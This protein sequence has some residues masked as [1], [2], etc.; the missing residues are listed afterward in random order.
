MN[1]GRII[2]TYLGVTFGETCSTEEI[3]GIFCI[4]GRLIN[5]LL[6]IVGA[7]SLVMFVVGGLQYMISGGDEKAL[8]TAKATLTYAVLGLF[9]V[10]LSSVIV[11]T[12]LSA[13]GFKP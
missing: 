8:T 10:L 3:I 6:A 7:I 2:E 9:I 11:S 4:I 1:V 5:Y 13:I 12:V